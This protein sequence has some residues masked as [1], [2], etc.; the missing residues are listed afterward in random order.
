MKTKNISLLP[1]CP[2]LLLLATI[3]F[4]LRFYLIPALIFR[5]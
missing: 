1:N 2:L 5:A 3:A 4:T